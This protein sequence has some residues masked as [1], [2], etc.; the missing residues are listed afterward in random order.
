FT[1]YD[2]FVVPADQLLAFQ[3]DR[4]SA[5]VGRKLAREY[6]W[7]I[8]DQVPLKG[9]IY[10]GVWSFTIQ[11]IYESADQAVDERQFILHWSYVNQTIKTVLPS[12]ADQVGVFAINIAHPEEAASV[13]AAIDS[14]FRNS[15]SETRTETQK[16]FQLG[17]IAMV[18]TI[19]LA[20][21]AV[22]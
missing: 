18:E 5:I 15:L 1:V 12:L 17:F 14:N 7:Q 20:I 9:T 4:R 3:R 10:P 6:G 21:Q 2:E 22:A 19:L 13:S 11:G 16:A 8:G